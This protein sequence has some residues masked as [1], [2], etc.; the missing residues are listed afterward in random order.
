MIAIPQQ[1]IAHR[2]I[3]ASAPENTLSAFKLAKQ[4]GIEWV[5]FDVSLSL[6]RECVIFH[7]DDLDRCSNLSGPLAQ[8]SLAALKQG[9]FGSWF[10]PEYA[11]ETILELKSLIQWLQTNDMHFNLEIKVDPNI[12]WEPL[13][14]N[15]AATLPQTSW[16]REH[17]LV[18]SFHPAALLAFSRL[19]EDV[20]LGILLDEP[21]QHWQDWAEGV[22]ASTVNCNYDHLTTAFAND[23]VDAGYQLLVYT[24]NTP[25]QF[26]TA[27]S[28]HA[29]AVFSDNPERL[30]QP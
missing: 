25:E 22:N 23:V 29:T 19:R 9:D 27:L 24:V 14:E 13:V 10:A 28:L 21:M 11:G 8:Q 17:C 1:V 26:E 3:S 15:I 7:D 18:S 12:A 4:H 16:L 6:D 2:G 30:M 20:P 5:E